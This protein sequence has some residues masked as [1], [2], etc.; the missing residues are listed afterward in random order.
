MVN[1]NTPTF[2]SPSIP[3]SQR[4]NYGEYPSL[5]KYEKLSSFSPEKLK[6]RS[7]K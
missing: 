5:D 1:T 6:T 4:G 2:K 7:K 3:L